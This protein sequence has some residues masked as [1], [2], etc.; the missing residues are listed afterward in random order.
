MPKWVTV[1]LS[2][3]FYTSGEVLSYLLHSAR[4]HSYN[5]VGEAF[6]YL[7]AGKYGQ[8]IVNVENALE[9]INSQKK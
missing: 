1:R 6:A 7:P 2:R 9:L 3:N 5:S 8:G 4:K